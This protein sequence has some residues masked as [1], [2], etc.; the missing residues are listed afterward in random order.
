M[1]KAIG[2][3]WCNGKGINMTLKT[4]P[5]IHKSRKE[6]NQRSLITFMFFDVILLFLLELIFVAI[7]CN[8]VNEL[9]TIEVLSQVLIGMICL[10]GCRGVC[11]IYD[12]GYGSITTLYIRLAMSD[13]LAGC[14]YIIFEKLLFWNRFS[15]IYVFSIVTLNLLLSISVR[16]V[17][18]FIN[19]RNSCI[20]DFFLNL[21]GYTSELKIK[22]TTIGSKE[23]RNESVNLEGVEFNMP[24][25][26]H[27]KE[28]VSTSTEMRLNEFQK[29]NETFSEDM[30]GQLNSEN[31]QIH[32]VE[33]MSDQQDI[34]TCKRTDCRINC[35]ES[36]FIQADKKDKLRM[37]EFDIE[38]LLFR[39]SRELTDEKT[40]MNYQSKVILITGGG[41]S[42]GSE[43][44]KQLAKMGPKQLII[45]DICEN[46][47][48]D[49][50]QEL[51]FE[52]GR[53]LDTR[54]EIVSICDRRELDKVFARYKPD[55]VLH[56]AA[57]KHVPLMEHNCCEAV[58]N[59]VFG[60]L[61]VVDMAERHEVEKFILISTDKAVNPTNVMGATKRLCEMIIQ[62]R[63]KSK[64]NFSATRFGNVLGSNGSVIPLFKHQIANGGPV[65]V[66]DKRI[67]RYFM[68]IP[69]A[70]Q[71]VLQSGAMAG[72]GELY[73][74]DMGKPVKILEMAENMIRLSG[75]EPY[76][77]IDIVEIGLRPGEKLYEELL[78]KTEE[79]DRTSNSLIFIERDKPQ[80]KEIIKHKL[81]ILSKAL[82]TEDDT[83]VKTALKKV[84][85]TFHD[86]E[87]VNLNA[88]ETLKMQMNENEKILVG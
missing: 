18:R 22:P 86:P 24:P 79:L 40:R 65:T 43:L 19:S 88:A 29:K 35:C 48:Y 26:M 61:N 32:T 53:K 15:L 33:K 5:Q 57:H 44:C 28:C 10:F 58:K 38:E 83:I 13:I 78:I 39:K 20:D 66:T 7:Y 25:L 41:G 14:I 31:M 16:F 1:K 71:L 2:R 81:D 82:I 73:V 68:T 21:I 6:N 72:N 11:K 4:S 54:L 52:Y 12:N 46:G 51:S 62:S 3:K 63:V 8:K 60:T 70:S 47:A 80:D 17:Y 64:T 36:P 37:K 67:I 59:N 9:N 34:K 87:E 42:I 75:F 84:V 76:K 49:I 56:A 85:S 77:D 30:E 74:L 45:L 27:P 23:F 50:Q 55:I 69:E